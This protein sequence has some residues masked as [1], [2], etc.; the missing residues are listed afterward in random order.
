MLAYW[1]VLQILKGVD[2][3]GTYPVARDDLRVMVWQFEMPV[4]VNVKR[5]RKL[6]NALGIDP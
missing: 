2:V 6:C 1:V 3:L 4:Q 5:L